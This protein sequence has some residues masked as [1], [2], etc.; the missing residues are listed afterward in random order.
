MKLEKKRALVARTLGVGNDR[1]IF[2]ANS[3]SS[4]KEA[5]TKQDV[6]DLIGAGAIKVRER[7]GRKAVERRLSRR[8]YG[9]IKKKVKN[10]KSQYIILT[11]KL[12]AYLFQLRE[13]KRI[14]PQ[15]YETLRKEIKMKSFRS[16]SHMKE[17]MKEMHHG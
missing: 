11:R 1:I 5:I 8:R 3:L 10:S 17:R 13:K 4:I 7:K 6:R 2:N 14:N 16:L 12:R 15:D 9:S